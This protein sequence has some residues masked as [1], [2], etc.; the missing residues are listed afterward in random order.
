MKRLTAILAGI[1]KDMQGLEIAPWHAPLV[2]K[3]DGWNSYILDVFDTP[4]LQSK[5][6]ADPNIKPSDHKIEK[7]DFVGSAV[8]I[9]DLVPSKLH[10]TFDYIVSSHNFEHLPNPIRFLQGCQSVLK[11]GGT[12]SM[13]V[14]DGRA[15]FDYFRPHTVTADWL[16]AF[17]HKRTRPSDK[18]I[19]TTRTSFAALS[20]GVAD[21]TAFY[22]NCNVNGVKCTSPLDAAPRFWELPPSETYLDTHCSVMTPASLRLMLLDLTHLG[23]LHMSVESISQP[24]GCEFF[25]R[26]V[27]EE[28]ARLTATDLQ[29]ERNRLMRLIWRER[30]GAGPILADASALPGRVV[31][32]AAG[33]LRLLAG[34]AR[35]RFQ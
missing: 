6:E 31:K 2:A 8:D 23:L 28:P 20:T 15:C 35:R 18:D 22:V 21:V 26:L 33:Q 14:P 13:A 24:N 34:M 12:L 1:S 30:T 11:P 25:V 10:Q 19:F 5:A 9:A 29:A 16:E 3:R 32:R 27:N 4:T 17:A 7:V